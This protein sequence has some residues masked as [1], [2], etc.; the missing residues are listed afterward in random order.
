MTKSK[1]GLKDGKIIHY[2]VGVLIKKGNKYLLVDRNTPPFGFAGIAGHID[3]GETPLQALRR[4]V[5]E[6]S[7]LKLKNERLIFEEFIDWNWCSQGV[8]G[9]H[10]YLFEGGVDGE[11]H[12]NKREAKKIGWYG[13]EEIKNLKLE[14]VWEYWF[15][16]LK[17]V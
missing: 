3:R 6:E 16:K 12:E 8:T 13:R 5:F 14:P 10:W 4:E 1:T 9:H 2:S 7:G 11:I 17:L 15:K